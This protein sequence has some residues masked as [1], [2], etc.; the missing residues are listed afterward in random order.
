MSNLERGFLTVEILEDCVGS[1]IISSFSH[2]HLFDAFFIVP[3]ANALKSLCYAFLSCHN[4]RF[5]LQ[6]YTKYFVIGHC[7]RKTDYMS[8][9]SGSVQII[10]QNL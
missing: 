5:L 9:S 7:F 2:F 10:S 6:N 8:A 4:V 3:L 1:G